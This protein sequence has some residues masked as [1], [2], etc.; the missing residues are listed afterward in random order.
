MTE[1]GGKEL[2]EASKKRRRRARRNKEKKEGERGE[3]KG[4]K[5]KKK[6]ISLLHRVYLQTVAE[7]SRQSQRGSQFLSFIRLVVYV[8]SIRLPSAMLL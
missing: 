5:K 7:T 4:R 1:I 6:K 8:D 3:E 2:E